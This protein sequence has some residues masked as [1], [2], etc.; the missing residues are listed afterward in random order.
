MSGVM[1]DKALS[2]SNGGGIKGEV[3][4][5]VCGSHG[6]DIMAG[7]AHKG[8]WKHGGLNKGGLVDGMMIFAHSTTSTTSSK[9]ASTAYQRPITSAAGRVGLG[10]GTP[11]GGPYPH[12]R[13]QPQGCVV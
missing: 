10:S 6:N 5:G 13:W 9:S 2:K 8:A 1:K 3:I 12:P 11:A 4:T 7:C